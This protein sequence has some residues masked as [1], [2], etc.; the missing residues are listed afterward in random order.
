[1]TDYKKMYFI[2]FNA[3][4]DA[5]RLIEKG[6]YTSAKDILDNAQITTEELYIEAE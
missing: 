1:M 3:I 4:T 6:E 5:S 2:L